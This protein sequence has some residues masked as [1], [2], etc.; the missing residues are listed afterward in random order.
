MLQYFSLENSCSN[1][2]EKNPVAVIF[3]RKFMLRYFSRQN[4]WCTYFLEKIHACLKCIFSAGAWSWL[5]RC[6]YAFNLRKSEILGTVDRNVQRN[7]LEN[8][9]DIVRNREEK[10]TGIFSRKFV[11]KVEKKI[12]EKN[13]VKNGEKYMVDT[14]CLLGSYPA[15]EAYYY[16]QCPV[17]MHI[18]LRL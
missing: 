6:F 16:R 5:S 15:A 2:L 11:W 3:S 18:F 1:F 17:P 10:L 8:S 9:R 12:L 4:S 13:P 14:T 7:S